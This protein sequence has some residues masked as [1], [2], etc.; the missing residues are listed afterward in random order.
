[1]AGEVAAVV[2]APQP[3]SEDRAEISLPAGWRVGVALAVVPPSLVVAIR[4]R[5]SQWR[6]LAP[7][8]AMTVVAFTAGLYRV[9][10][11]SAGGR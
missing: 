3:G 7:I 9:V 8:L 2:V 1:M 6:S 10:R 5:E 4:S 11:R